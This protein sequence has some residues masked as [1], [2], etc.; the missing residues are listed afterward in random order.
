[1]KGLDSCI[2]DCLDCHRICL[3][4]AMNHCLESGGKHVEPQHFRSMMACA[5]ICATAAR[6]MMMSSPLHVSTC[7]ACA[8]ICEA[9]AV[10]CEGLDGME[11]CVKACRQCAASCRQMVE[12]GSR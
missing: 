11:D 5:E 6:L 1:M 7:R 4:M 12:A 10:S 2:K 9:C 8:E 3:S